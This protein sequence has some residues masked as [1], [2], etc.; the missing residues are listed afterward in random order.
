MVSSRHTSATANM[1]APPVS[2]V[3]SLLRP[4]LARMSPR[5][6]IALQCRVSQCA[7]NSKTPRNS[8]GISI[9]AS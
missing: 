6:F 3:R 7:R 2:A 5:Y 8:A 9:G 4:K 1:I